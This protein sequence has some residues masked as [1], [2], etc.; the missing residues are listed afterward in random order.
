MRVNEFLQ[1]HK[2]FVTGVLSGF[3]RILFRGT[4]RNMVIGTGMARYL[5]VNRILLK[6]DGADFEAVTKEVKYASLEVARQAERPVMHLQSSRESKE[7][8]ARKIAARDSIA[9]GLI[10]VLTAVE[11]C[12]TVILYRNRET[13]TLDLQSAQRKCL[14]I[15]HYH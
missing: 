15:Y 2:A 7:E 10:C 8:I 1:K 6:D 9:D 12:R 3:D 5:N 13:K 14:F 4:L 11:P